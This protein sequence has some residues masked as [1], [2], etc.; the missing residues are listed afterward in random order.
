MIIN[1]SKNHQ[2]DMNLAQL[3]DNFTRTLTSNDGLYNDDYFSF[4]RALE[5]YNQGVDL[6]V[7][8]KHNILSTAK[9]FI[10]NF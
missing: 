7:A 5:K 10:N 2:F 4:V 8:Y 6:S 9:S 1:D 3:A